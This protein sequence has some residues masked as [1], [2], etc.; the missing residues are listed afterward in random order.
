MATWSRPFLLP[1]PGRTV[2]TILTKVT[3]NL[4][5]RFRAV[6]AAILVVLAVP[7]TLPAASAAQIVIFAAASLKEA[8][9]EATRVYDAQTGDTVKISYAASSALA[10]QIESGAPAD[11]FISADLDWMDYLQQRDLIQ[12]GTRNRLLGNRLVIVAAADN[13]LKLDI[14][15]GFDLAGALKGGRLAMA[16]PDSVPA[17]KYGKAALEKLGVWNAV[18]GAVAPA[19]SV[20]VAL[21]FVSRREA[22]LGIVYATDAAADPRVKIAGTFPEDS[23]PPIVYPVALTADSK[24]PDAAR[25]LA[26]LTSPAVRPIFEKHGFTVLP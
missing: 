8:L 14:K 20:R 7:G 13:P 19:E 24:N 6:A 10:K 21:L 22:P 23:H 25:L 26:F 17:G 4:F 3:M 1:I 5:H 18:K 12:P 9:D 15:P 2:A 16:D 11:M